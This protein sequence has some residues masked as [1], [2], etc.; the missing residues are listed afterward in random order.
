MSEPSFGLFG[1]YTLS[2]E[3][4]FAHNTGISEEQVAEIRRFLDPMA[5]AVGGTP[6]SEEQLKKVTD[7]YHNTYIRTITE[8]YGFNESTMQE[9]KTDFSEIAKKIMDVIDKTE[10][11]PQKK[12]QYRAYMDSY[13]FL[14]FNIMPREVVES[15]IAKK[16][17]EENKLMRS[18]LADVSKNISD[19]VHNVS[20]LQ[21]MTS[22]PPIA[23]AIFEQ[24]PD[25]LTVNNERSMLYYYQNDMDTYYKV[26]KHVKNDMNNLNAFLTNPVAFM[27]GENDP[28]FDLK[29]AGITLDEIKSLK[30]LI[31]GLQTGK[32]CFP[33][34]HADWTKEGPEPP[35]DANDESCR[36][37]DKMGNPNSDS[38]GV[39]YRSTD[40]GTGRYTWQPQNQ[41]W[42]PQNQSYLF[43]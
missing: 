27:G 35:M 16:C 3:Q 43:Q 17:V 14:Y 40:N 19:L 34:T 22:V 12:E 36:G 42:Q 33:K 41:N 23:R 13:P 9:L 32:G 7:R 39:I 18:T 11:D 29:R 30:E 10:G 24:L 28:T 20:K 38:A 5:E 1:Q 31:I 8:K 6:L 21:V 2:E 25:P 26:H 37:K 4:A 15:M